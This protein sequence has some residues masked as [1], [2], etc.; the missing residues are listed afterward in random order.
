MG[1]NRLF[2]AFD[3]FEHWALLKSINA[4]ELGGQG[5]HSQNMTSA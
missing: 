4:L 5:V 2:P 3:E 1:K